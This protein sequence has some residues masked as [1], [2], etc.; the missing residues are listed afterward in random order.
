MAQRVVLV[1][2]GETEWSISRRHTG[3]TDIPL[4]A[5]GRMLAEGLRPILGAITGIHEALIL[6][7]PLQ[8]AHDTCVLSGLG[9][10]AV[11]E[12]DLVEWDY[13][14][15]EG[16]RTDEMRQTTPG[17]S[18]WTHPLTGGE[19]LEQ[20]GGRVDR[21]LARAALEDRLVVMFAH[22]HVLRILAAR[23]CG[24]DAGLGR[25]LTLDP[26]SVSILGHEREVP[27]IERWNLVAT[28]DLERF[29]GTA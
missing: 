15:A 1:R 16:K 4:N 19:S 13:G 26:A 14:V 9:P 10:R 29:T 17:W 25:I 28:G 22:A 11:V 18:V 23:W 21:V 5:E 27:V 3:R 6:S 20:V 7:S 8:R 24:L 12:P 2:H